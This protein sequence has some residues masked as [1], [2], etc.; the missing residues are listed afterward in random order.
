VSKNLTS[1]GI[2]A[3]VSLNGT[4]VWAHAFGYTDIEND[5]LARVDS[6]WR[7]SSISKSLTSALI[8]RLI[9]EGTLDLNKSIDEYLKPNIFPIKNWNNKNV[10]ITLG[11]VM[12]HTAGLHVFKFPDDLYHNLNMTNV[13][14][15]IAQFK[16]EPLLFEPG[17]NWNYSN[18]GYQVVGA[19][20]ESVLNE[21]YESAINKM[22]KQLEMNKTFCERRENIIP[23]RARSYIKSKVAFNNQKP[24]LENPVFAVELIS[25]EAYWPSIGIVSTIPDLLKY[26]SNMIQWSK[27]LNASKTCNYSIY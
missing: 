25:S 5:V 27:G 18:Y 11:Q 6:V 19:I 2:V 23:N 4:Q 24:K 20:I 12:S 10:T 3:G 1:P 7:M 8:A 16:D 21:T 14:Q 26:G 22:F 13:T 9:D 17:T 15:T